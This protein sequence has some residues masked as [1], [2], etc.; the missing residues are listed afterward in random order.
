MAGFFL[1]GKKV[2]YDVGLL[3]LLG[4]TL[5]IMRTA[6]NRTSFEVYRRD[7]I[8]EF[9]N[10]HGKSTRGVCG[11]ASSFFLVSIG[12][13]LICV[14]VRILPLHSSRSTF[15]TICPEIRTYEIG[16][17]WPKH[18]TLLATWVQFSGV[19]ST[20]QALQLKHRVNLL[21]SPWAWRTQGRAR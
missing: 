17:D 8:R 13:S 10:C 21:Y 16:K 11:S 18:T 19:D 20:S 5:G 15:C 7:A 4:V 1:E 6:R 14:S 12:L 3:V 9:W 2:V